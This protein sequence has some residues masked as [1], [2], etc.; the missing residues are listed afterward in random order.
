M[1]YVLQQAFFSLSLFFAVFL[2]FS[3]NQKKTKPNQKK[4]CIDTNQTKKKHIV[5]KNSDRC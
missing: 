2:S 4:K 3:V 5:L 1:T